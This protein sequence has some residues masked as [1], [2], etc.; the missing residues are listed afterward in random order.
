[1]VAGSMGT[2]RP[3]FIKLAGFTSRIS[4]ASKSSGDKVDGPSYHVFSRRRRGAASRVQGDSI[5]ETGMS[6]TVSNTMATNTR[7]VNDDDDDD[8][9]RRSGIGAALWALSEGQ[10]HDAEK[11][12]CCSGGACSYKVSQCEITAS[13][14][15]H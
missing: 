9:E 11:E 1:M 6:M 10:S 7:A 15:S 12:C 5:L 2:L 8:D 13:S 3:L 4:Q 14:S